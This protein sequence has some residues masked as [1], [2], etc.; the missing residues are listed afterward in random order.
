MDD[1]HQSTRRLFLLL[2]GL[3]LAVKALLVVFLADVFFYGEELEKGTAAK[4]MLDGLQVPHHQLAYHY[5]E[6]GGF[7]ISHLKALAFLVVGESIL[8]HKLVAL[9]AVGLVFW[10]GWRLVRHHFGTRAALY[11]ALLFVFAAES[12]QKLTL[13]S[14]GIHFESAF[15]ALLV[16]D[17]GMRLLGRE[18]HSKRDMLLFG[19][20]SGFGIYFSY[21][22]ALVVGFV[23][24]LLLVRRRDVVLGRDGLVGFGGLL[25]GLAPFFAMYALVGDAV[26]DIHGTALGENA[27]GA[28]ETVGVFLSSLYVDKSFGQLLGPLVYPLAFLLATVGVLCSGARRKAGVLLGFLLFWL[29]IYLNSAFV[30]GDVI[31]D[32]LLLRFSL[33][34]LVGVIVLAAALAQVESRQVARVV[35][36]LLVALGLWNTVV[37]IHAG[38]P[39][40]PLKNM[41]VL[42]STKGYDYQGY[43]AKL[44]K[45][46]EGDEQ[47]R[48][49]KL[50][51]FDEPDRGLLYAD[52][53]LEAFRSPEVLDDDVFLILS[54]LDPK[55]LEDFYRG[56]GPYQARRAGGNLEQAVARAQE[57]GGSQGDALLE[58]VGRF[59]V[60]WAVFPETLEVEIAQF[61]GRPGLEPFFRGVGYRFYRRCVLGPRSGVRYALKPWR[62][63]EFL[64]AQPESARAALLAGFE[65]A[66][67]EHSLK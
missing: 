27:P 59:G 25:I 54:T 20:V 53:T 48:L 47:A 65:A 9:L 12:F 32:F 67:A 61:A 29:A 17:Y 4:A 56:L 2:L 23:G 1:A 51:D 24:L 31:H 45:H 16:F 35:C 11:F 6:G 30:I 19:I 3:C 37:A 15:F 55:G 38:S 22:L 49:A 10:A 43:F 62:G 14:L 18:E 8:A 44:L 28:F 39:T 21:Q 42:A 58:G 34:W 50:L 33:L 26:F 66:I 52:M 7:V 57:R 64:A 41:R 60:D 13:L 63:R 46:L 40:T 5:Y 36:G